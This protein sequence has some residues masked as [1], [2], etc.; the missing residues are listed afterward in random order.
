MTK[1]TQRT[2][3][4][5]ILLR[6]YSSAREEIEVLVNELNE[7][8]EKLRK[9]D[10]EKNAHKKHLSRKDLEVLQLKE[11][12]SA[13]ET[14][15]KLYIDSL[16]QPELVP[17][18]IEK[19]DSYQKEISK[20]QIKLDHER[21][22]GKRN[23]KEIVRLNELLKHLKTEKNSFR[24]SYLEWKNWAGRLEQDVKNLKLERDILDNDYDRC[25]QEESSR[26][27]KSKAAITEKDIK[28]YLKIIKDNCTYLED[29]MAMYV[30]G[31]DN[32]ITTIK[33]KLIAHF[34][35]L[36]EDI[37]TVFFLHGPT[38]VGKTYAVEILNKVLFKNLPIKPKLLV[39][40]MSEYYDDHL[41]SKLVGSPPGY[42]GYEDESLI[43]KHV[44]SNP[45][46]SIVLLDE[47]EK[48]HPGVYDFFLHM[49]DKGIVEDCQNNVHQVN[50][51]I[52]FL[53]SNAGEHLAQQEKTIG[54]FAK[55]TEQETRETV[56]G[57]AIQ[58]IF[59]PEF[60]NRI[61]AKILFDFLTEEAI[62]DILDVEFDKIND[63]AY[64]NYGN[65][66]FL[67]KA[68]RKRIKE[69]G[70]DK[71][72][73]ARFLKRTLEEHIQGSSIVIDLLEKG[74]NVFI[75]YKKDKFIYK[76]LPPKNKKK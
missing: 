58:D 31:Q 11:T 20:K 5:N 48:A 34:S 26:S 69:I 37:P 27:K 41:V 32:A 15:L 49:F 4:E 8:E 23:E 64:A 38:G 73:G 12:K 66:I 56:I 18:L 61:G 6:Q 59:S 50:K 2:Q 62:E 47:M 29:K 16:D 53:T 21:S 76:T 28:L 68:A 51:Y 75:D 45:V 30:K 9:S 24:K 36:R 14:K 22:A 60:R 72:T 17:W 13:L 55:D 1:K 10:K 65:E 70:F 44:N 42:V 74:K 39:A 46:F 40:N 7:L 43:S 3:L 52:F 57:G 19:V 33:K 63:R 54:G 25:W 35:G 71:K 67:L